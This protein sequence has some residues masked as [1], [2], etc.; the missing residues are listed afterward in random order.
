MLS[1]A[2]AI[3]LVAEMSDDAHIA[4]TVAAGS[5]EGI[6]N[7]L[8]ANRAEEVLIQLSRSLADGVE[9]GE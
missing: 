3:A 2:R 5:E 7:D 6:P 4:E 1:A 8:H 9:L